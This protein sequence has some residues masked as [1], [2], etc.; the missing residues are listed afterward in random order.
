MEYIYT[1]Q[2]PHSTTNA[3]S[4]CISIIKDGDQLRFFLPHNL[5]HDSKEKTS[6]NKC[7]DLTKMGI[8]KCPN[9]T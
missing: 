7:P 3:Y 5:V 2:C 8:I 4:L 9:L 6:I 1:L